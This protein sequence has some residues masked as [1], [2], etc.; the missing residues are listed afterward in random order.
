MLIRAIMGLGLI[1]LGYYVGR[2]VGRHEGLREEL[3]RD[4][5]PGD[6]RS[7]EPDGGTEEQ[8]ADSGAGERGL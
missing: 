1:G 2:E 6:G 7:A 3:A 4:G 8:Q 5:G